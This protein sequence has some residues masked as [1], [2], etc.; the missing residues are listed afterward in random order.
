ME[1]QWNNCFDYGHAGQR[2]PFHQLDWERNRLFFGN[3]QSGFNHNGRTHNRDGDFHAQLIDKTRD[4]TYDQKQ[5][6]YEITDK[7]THYHII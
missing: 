1:R 4:P 2:L 6:N 3:E 5:N 7:Y